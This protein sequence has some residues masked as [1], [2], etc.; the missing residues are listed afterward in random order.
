MDAIG[1]DARFV[2]LSPIRHEDLRATRPGLPDPAEHNK[3]L[4]AYTKAIE[5]LAT[6][7]GARFANIA[8]ADH[9]RVTD[10][11][12]HLSAGGAGYVFG[13][14]RWGVKVGIAGGR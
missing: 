9:V 2:L 10:N 3:L 6:G 13:A 7:A 12:I 4:E 5:E 8:V 14:G 11:G 1:K